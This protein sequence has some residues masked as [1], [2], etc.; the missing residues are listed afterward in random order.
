MIMLTYFAFTSLSTVGLGDYHPVSN[1]ER[2]T[3]AFILLFGVS[4]TSFIMDNLNKMI[5]QL[6]S[7]QKPYEQN[8]EMSLFLGTLEKFN[9]SKKLLPDHQQEILEYF[10]YR[11]RFNKNNA[12]STQQDIDLL[13]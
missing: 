8:N 6:N 7:I 11:W 4:I 12:I 3:G 13:I 10:E 9:G 5:L 2:F 1:F